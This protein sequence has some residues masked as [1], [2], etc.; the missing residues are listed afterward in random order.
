[1]KNVYIYVQAC[2]KR[3]MDAKRIEDYLIK[4]NYNV[5]NNPKNADI[6]IFVTCAFLD[7]VT[8]KNFEKIEEFKKLNSELIIAGCLPE[9]EK[10]RLSKVF[11]GK[12]LNTKNLEKIDTIFPENKVKFKDTDDANILFENI[13]I[14]ST[15]GLLKYYVDQNQ[16]LNSAI[17]KVRNHIMK[18]LS[19]K[20]SPLFKALTTKSFHLRIS[21]GCLGNCTYCAIKPAV[22]PFKSKPLDQCIKEL[23]KGLRK[24]YTNFILESDDVGAY[25]YDIKSSFPELLDKLTS[26]PGDYVISIRALSPRWVVKYYDELGKILGRGKILSLGIAMQSANSRILK[27]MNRYSDMEKIKDACILLKKVFPH[28]GIDTHFILG[29]PS[30]T[31]EDFEDNLKFIEETNFNVG[32]FIPFSL[33]TGTKAEKIEPKI[34][35]KEISDRMKYAKNYLKKIGYHVLNYKEEEC[36][37]LL[38]NK[39][40]NQ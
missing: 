7:N 5:I 30:E 13:D 34:S 16:Y 33:K 40:G 36:K 31:F 15:S 37:I 6:I 32:Y 8:E 29:F 3:S 14:G 4:N 38:F 9:I 24:G 25:G 11:N 12:I 27:L 21:S 18:Y 2:R 17:S 28:L 1:M 23:K 22:G 39:R 19:Q 10:K 26:E 20:H 35:Q